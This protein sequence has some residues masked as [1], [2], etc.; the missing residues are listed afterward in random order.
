MVLEGRNTAPL[1]GLWFIQAT[2]KTSYSCWSKANDPH[3]SRQSAPFVDAI[4]IPTIITTMFSGGEEEQIHR[5]CSFWG[6]G[7]FAIAS[8]IRLLVCTQPI[9]KRLLIAP[10]IYEF[11]FTHTHDH[12]PIYTMCFNWTNDLLPISKASPERW[13][14]SHTRYQTVMPDVTKCS[15]FRLGQ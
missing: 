4:F 6:R 11:I 7:T 9:A 14:C 3:W 12:P 15:I 10:V 5:I 13:R 8:C 1:W 2:S